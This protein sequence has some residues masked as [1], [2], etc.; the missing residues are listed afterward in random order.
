MYG[1]GRKL[2]MPINKGALEVT[3][4]AQSVSAGMAGV[5]IGGAGDDFQ[6]FSSWCAV[7][8]AS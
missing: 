3:R 6:P 1:D 4:Y 5:G 8:A 2:E 7:G